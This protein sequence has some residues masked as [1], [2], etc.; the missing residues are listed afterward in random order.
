MKYEK[1]EAH[2]RAEAVLYAAGFL[3]ADSE[4]VTDS[5]SMMG[6]MRG[7]TFHFIYEYERGWLVVLPSGEG[8]AATLEDAVQLL[9]EYL[10]TLN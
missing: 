3:S 9:G 2:R 8:R 7:K 1:E 4:P 10:Q 6:R 5:L